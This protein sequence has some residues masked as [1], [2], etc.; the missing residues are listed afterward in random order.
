MVETRPYYLNN[1]SNEESM[2]INFWNDMKSCVFCVIKSYIIN[3]I[4]KKYQFREIPILRFDS[5]KFV[6][7]L[8]VKYLYDSGYKIAST[9][10]K[11]TFYY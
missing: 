7:N 1:L 11:S 9:L 6:H 4:P 2:I 8:L 10:G 3:G 5:T